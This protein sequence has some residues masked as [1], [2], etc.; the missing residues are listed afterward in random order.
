[1]FLLGRNKMCEKS[2]LR[3]VR[4][5]RKVVSHCFS[6]LLFDCPI[7]SLE[8]FVAEDDDN[9]YTVPILAE[10]YFLKNVQ[11]SI[12]IIDTDSDDENEMNN[13]VPFPTSS[14]MR[15]ILKTMRSYLDTQ[16]NG[17]MY[18]KMDDFEQLVDNLMLKNTMQRKISYYFFKTE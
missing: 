12:N 11:R 2:D 13:A 6:A 9:M 17:G 16:T 18:I 15:N 5:E 14:E 1:M 10:K 8:K 7:I 4:N 3:G